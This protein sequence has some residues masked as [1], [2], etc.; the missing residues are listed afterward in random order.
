MKPFF[1]AIIFLFSS[2]QVIAAELSKA[3]QATVESAIA[4]FN[5]SCKI[6]MKAALLQLE[7]KKIPRSYANWAKIL[8][9]PLEYCSCGANKLRKLATPEFVRNT[10][11]D[12][13]Y[14]NGLL[15]GA[16][17]VLPKLK[18]SFPEFCENFSAELFP[19]SRRDGQP[20]P[21]VLQFC[22]CLQGDVDNINEQDII[23][24][25]KYGEKNSQTTPSSQEFI[26]KALAALIKNMQRCGISNLREK[27][28]RP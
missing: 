2:W 28:S 1:I 14:S 10:N 20:M 23:E 18:T 5:T 21:E 19:N 15:I 12:V 25:A 27:Y 22:T 26:Q 4:N 13:G 7:D 11:P 8:I 24:M 3:E 17:C 9:D 16:Q 6:E